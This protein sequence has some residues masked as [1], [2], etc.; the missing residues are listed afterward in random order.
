MSIKIGSHVILLDDVGLWLIAGMFVCSILAVILTA[1][2]I[3]C[4]ILESE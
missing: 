2:L 1:Y 4:S 3:R